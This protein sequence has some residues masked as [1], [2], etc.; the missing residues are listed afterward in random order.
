MNAPRATD[1]FARLDALLG[2]ALELPTG[3]R[4]AFLAAHTE[5][6]LDKAQALALL[7]AAES[8]PDFVCLTV[9]DA[10][11][12]PGIPAQ[13]GEWHVLET[14]G[15]G[16]MADVVLAE[17]ALD[18]ATQLS[19]IKLLKTYWSDPESKR[20]FARERS[21]LVGLEDARIARLLDGGMLEDGRPWL[22]LEYIRG[23]HIDSWCDSRELDLRTRVRLVREVAGAVASAHRNLVIHRDIKPANVL[24]NGEGQVKLLDF[25]I[26][27]VVAEVNDG[28]QPSPATRSPAFT[29]EFASPEQLAGQRVS[30]ASDVYQLGLL[31]Y[32]LVTGVRPY[33]GPKGNFA[34]LVKSV[35]GSDAPAPA[36]RLANEPEQIA[37]MAQARSSSSTRLLRQLRGDLS[38]L[39]AKAL[40]RDPLQRY[41]SAL[42]F[43]DDLGNWLQGL[44]LRARPPSRLYRLGSLIRRNRLAS[45]LAA[46][47]L[48]SM[49]GYG[50]SLR[51]QLAVTE[52]EVQLN[53]GMRD[54]LTELF[55][56]AEPR[57]GR[58]P[59]TDA[60]GLL[61]EGIAAAR[62]EHADNPRLLAEL[63][64]VL[65]DSLTSRGE[66]ESAVGYLREAVAGLQREGDQARQSL[67]R[68]LQALGDV[69]HYSGLY[70]DAQATY[71]RLLELPGLSRA[72]SMRAR[73]SLAGLLH[74]RGR[75]SQAQVQAEGA[76]LQVPVSE[77]GSAGLRRELAGVFADVARDRAD[78]ASAQTW[79]LRAESEQLQLSPDN[80]A[81]LA[82]IRGSRAQTLALAGDLEQ[83]LQEIEQA[84]QTFVGARVASHAALAVIAYRRGLVLSAAGRDAQARVDFAATIESLAQNHLYAG[85]ARIGIA[86]LDLQGGIPE[87][88]LA[89][90]ALAKAAVRQA[91][92]DHPALAEI[93]MINALALQRLNRGEEAAAALEFAQESRRRNFGAEHPYSVTAQALELTPEPQLA[94]LDAE[95]SR[96]LEY[97][98]LARALRTP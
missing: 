18:D 28:E 86:W 85:H 63:L 55:L 5:G 7:R 88:A 74:T 9:L 65:G 17:R 46:C 70:A 73:T 78:F 2:Q 38:A 72:Q 75:Y 14:L 44:P 13:I 96:L 22:A 27:K 95:L 93:A 67:P 54:Y 4:E 90:T 81:R 66:Y 23:E 51:H 82:W 56:R 58:S 6:P 69:E 71:V 52:A 77:L 80:L 62:L 30:T 36:T 41:D 89:Q 60:L 39:L 79:L 35:T 53:R 49:T 94:A 32:V 20:R 47:L 3:E 11:A 34:A 12:G 68:A 42:S 59:A 76:W 45:G 37:R 29:P 50:L 40:A 57:P 21:I 19:A 1:R 8:A 10:A 91:D 48:L 43:A 84:Y 33:A 16:G 83:A 31:L 87:A 61:E 92:Q 25:G 97:R 98:R 26:A 15:A 64:L 24:V